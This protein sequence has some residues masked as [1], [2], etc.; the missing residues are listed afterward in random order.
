MSVRQNLARTP[1]ISATS[2]LKLR[3]AKMPLTLDPTIL[4]QWIGRSENAVDTLDARPARLMASIMPSGLDFSA[5]VALPPLWNW[6]Y[7]PTN[8]PLTEL[9]GDGHPALGGFLPPVN[10]PRRMWAGGRFEFS[11]DLTIGAQVERLSTITNVALKSGR[12]GKLCFVTVRHDYSSNGHHCL[13]EEHDI[14]YRDNPGPSAAKAEPQRAPEGADFTKTIYPSPVMLFR[15]SALTFNS[16]RIHYDIDYCRDVEGYPGLVFHGPLTA[17]LLANFAE[18]HWSKRLQTFEFRAVSPLFDIAPF[19]ICAKSDG[20][21]AK[22]WAET[23]DGNLA[24]IASARF[25]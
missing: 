18:Q 8:V 3:T 23:P 1:P 2:F 12:S 16:H 22:L 17:A 20:E 5:S 7:F 19:D 11:R 6:L 13:S 10:L 21:G 24:M 4:S 15:Y 9:G 14:V 25:K